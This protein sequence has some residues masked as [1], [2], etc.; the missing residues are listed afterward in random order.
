MNPHDPQPAPGRRKTLLA[1][2]AALLAARAN[3]QPVPNA[4]PNC[5]L[6]PRQT[7]GPYFVDERLRR[8]DI[9]SDP[10]G[11]PVQPGIP[12]A[13]TLRVLAV[14]GARCAPLPGAVVDVWHCDA[15]GAYSAVD[16][17]HFNTA[18]KSFLRGYQISDAGGAVR[19]L[20]IYPGWY[21]GRAVHIHFKVRAKDA[22]GRDAELTSQLYFDDAL[23]ARVHAQAPYSGRSGRAPRNDADGIFRQGGRQ[24][25][26]APVPQG[27]GYAAVFDVGLR[28]S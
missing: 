11:G 4:R 23:T 20:T 17:P 26:L 22:S 8:S 18:G 12:L 9:R 2:A 15:A 19:F 7:E 27:E 14:D 28:I 24:L 1:L 6:T 16:D 25:M 3:A 13:L 10:A 21:P 5:V